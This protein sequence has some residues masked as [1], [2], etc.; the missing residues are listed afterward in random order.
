MPAELKGLTLWNTKSKIDPKEYLAQKL[1]ELNRY[2]AE[3][4]SKKEE[5]KVFNFSVWMPTNAK[6]DERDLY[7]DEAFAK[8]MTK[9]T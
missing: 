5:K 8:G 2:V 7:E 6:P 1:E 3:P 9:Q 4:E